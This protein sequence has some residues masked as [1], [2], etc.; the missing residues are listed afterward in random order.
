MQSLPP[1]LFL[2]MLELTV[3]AFVTLYLL[4]LRGDTSRGYIVFQGVLYAFFALL[5]YGAMQAFAT[6]DLLCRVGLCKQNLDAAWLTWQQPLVIL[7][8]LLIIPWNVLLWMDRSAARK[9]GKHAADSGDAEAD[10]SRG[11]ARQPARRAR[12]AGDIAFAGDRQIILARRVVGALTSLLGFAAVF[13]VAMAYRPLAAAHLGG[14]FVVAA[15]FAGALALGGVT[16]AMLLGH[17]YLNTPTASGKPLEFTTSLLLVGLLAELA[18]AL[19]LGPSTAHTLPNATS[20]SPGTTI[21]TS[22][23][24]VVVTTPTPGKTGQP[25]QTVDR[26]TPIDTTA[27]LGLQYAMGILAPLILGGVALWLTRGRSFQ[28]ATG[29]LYLCM[30]FIFIGEILARGL[31][32]LPVL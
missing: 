22:G 3:G 14:A 31:L 6:K 28:S 18:F 10:E 25:T 27:M 12:A 30:A 26:I 15:F 8:A 24:T 5:T 1:A 17:W 32:L 2:V 21:Q 20:V 9:K 19:A 29:M 13:V 11:P 7:F 16:T 4:D 23:G